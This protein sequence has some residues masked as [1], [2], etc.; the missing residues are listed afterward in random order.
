MQ[1]QEVRLPQL[2]HELTG[3]D[4]ELRETKVSLQM[5]IVM[6]ERAVK[7]RQDQASKQMMPTMRS[8]ERDRWPT[9]K[10]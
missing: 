1:V 2:L 4:L 5:R 3:M 6:H 9:L 10:S 7:Y 8:T